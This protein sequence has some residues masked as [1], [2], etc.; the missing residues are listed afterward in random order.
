MNDDDQKWQAVQF[1][2]TAA[3]DLLVGAGWA[4]RALNFP[5]GAVIELTATGHERMDRIFEA[6]EELGPHTM[7]AEHIMGL[8]LYLT[9]RDEDAHPPGDS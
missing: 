6:L 9:L 5:H 8:F 7:R 4:T 1:Q 2:L 3:G